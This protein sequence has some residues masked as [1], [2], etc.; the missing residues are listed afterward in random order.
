M[1]PDGCRCCMIKGSATPPRPMQ[2]DLIIPAPDGLETISYKL[3]QAICDA[4]GILI[5][6]LD[7]Y[8]FRDSWIVDDQEIP[9]DAG[10]FLNFIREKL[11]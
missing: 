3:A 5:P 9:V 2:A 11:S 8:G 7:R 1:A 6:F 4:S 10:E